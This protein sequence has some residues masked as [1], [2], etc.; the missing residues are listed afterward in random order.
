MAE[1]LTDNW[2]LYPPSPIQTLSQVSFPFIFMFDRAFVPEG[3]TISAVALYLSY[4]KTIFN[5][6]QTLYDC[7]LFLIVYWW[8]VPDQFRFLG[9]YTPTPPLSWHL[10]WLLT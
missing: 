6:Y 8:I 4:Y 5:T 2:H 7:A 3:P 10:H 1:I 9:N